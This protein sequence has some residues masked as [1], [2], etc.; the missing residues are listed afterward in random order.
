[1]SRSAVLYIRQRRVF[2]QL[3]LLAAAAMGWWLYLA[4]KSVRY[5]AVAAP[6]FA[7]IV[8]AAAVAFST[9]R[10]RRRLAAAVCLIYA[11]NQIAGNAYLAWRFRHADY[12]RLSAELRQTIPLDATVYGANTFWL[13]LYDRRFYSYDRSP[14]DYAIANFKPTHLILYD[15]LMLGGSGFGVDDFQEVRTK[16]SAFVGA[17][18]ERIETIADPFYGNLEIYRVHY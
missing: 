1:M 3:V 11:L 9:S 16:A 14:F 2:W 10:T 17:H 5:T 15:R 18:G 6:V 7:L 4:N 8:A 12:G 13:A